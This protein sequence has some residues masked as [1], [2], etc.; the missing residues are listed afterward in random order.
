MPFLT[1][2]DAAVVRDRLAREMVHPV[3]LEF[4][5]PTTS[6]LALPTDDGQIAEYVRQI[7]AEVAA[8]SPLVTVVP[9]STLAE[10]ER[11]RAR[12]I[13]CTP[14]TAVLG[15]QDYG[16]RFYGMPAGYEFATLLEMIVAASRGRG[17]L[18]PRTREVL[19]RLPGEAHIRVFVTPT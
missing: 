7:L 6:G 3:T 1:E 10:P 12:G 14:A 15:A 13:A 16:L 9:I 17:D 11:A 2:H 5:A 19:E 4:Y 18:S 8:L